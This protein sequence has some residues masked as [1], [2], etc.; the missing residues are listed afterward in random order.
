[1][2]WHTVGVMHDRSTTYATLDGNT[3]VMKS[4][5]QA[6]D[7]SPLFKYNAFG[8]QDYVYIGGSAQ[9]PHHKTAGDIYKH[10]IFRVSFLLSI[11]LRFMSFSRSKPPL[12]TRTSF[13]AAF[14]PS[15]LAI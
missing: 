3:C 5:S 6:T 15:Q 4:D 13:T 12:S 14:I 2:Q 11:S 7:R 1:M 9:V 8:P 10:K